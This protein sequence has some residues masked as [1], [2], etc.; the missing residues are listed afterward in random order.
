MSPR[1]YAKIEK[2]EGRGCLGQYSSLISWI[3][4]STSVSGPASDQLEDRK[5][6]SILPQSPANNE[7][8]SMRLSSYHKYKLIRY[9]PQL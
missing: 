8:V 5:D 3:Y 1:T 2:S 4:T 6:S 9:S 7:L